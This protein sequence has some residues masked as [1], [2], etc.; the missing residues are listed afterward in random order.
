MK[1]ERH[2]MAKNANAQNRDMGTGSVK[3]WMV[4][5]AVPA[6]VAVPELLAAP[7]SLAAALRQ[8]LL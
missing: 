3:K 8:Y 2:N 1:G 6:L 5:L 7:L 4:Q